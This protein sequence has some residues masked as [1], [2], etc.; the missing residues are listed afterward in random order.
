MKDTLTQTTVSL[1]LE[2]SPEEKQTYDD[3]LYVSLCC[4]EW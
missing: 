1:P 3:V 2:A 4:A